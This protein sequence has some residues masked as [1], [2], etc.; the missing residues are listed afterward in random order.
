MPTSA[1]NVGIYLLLG[2]L[3][4]GSWWVAEILGPQEEPLPKLTRGR[5]DYYSTDIRRT[6]L[7]ET[8]RPKELLLAD[9]M[10]HYENDKH[11]ELT[12]PIMT[13]Y[14]KQGPPWVIHADSAILPGDSDNVLLYGAVLILREADEN[15]RTVRIETSNAR[16]QPERNYAETDDFIRLLSPPDTMTGTGAQVWFGDNLKFT[17][18]ANVRRKHEV[19]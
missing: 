3:A 1:K 5:V 19:E 18:L 17:V 10:V 12:R 7:D 8:G 2:L 15:G 6:V 4:L 16:V 13:L 11:T 14:G 9:R